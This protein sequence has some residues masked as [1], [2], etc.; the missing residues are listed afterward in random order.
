MS[1]TVLA[2]AFYDQVLMELLVAVGGA[3]FIG[4]VLALVRRRREAADSAHPAVQPGDL[5][6][7]PVARTTVYAVLGFV[8]MAWGIASLVAS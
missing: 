7:A 1:V 3:L 6:R 2:V 8:V 5:E 4:N